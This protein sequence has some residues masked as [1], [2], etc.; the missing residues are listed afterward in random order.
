VVR[1]VDP[2]NE[3]EAFLAFRKRFIDEGIASEAYSDI[4]GVYNTLEAAAPEE[5]KEKA[6]SYATG[7]LDHIKGLY[8]SMDS[9]FN[10]PRGKKREG[11]RKAAGGGTITLDLKGTPCP[12]NYVKAKL[13]L[14]TLEAGATVEIYLDEGEPI[15]NVP[16]SLKNDGHII[17][18]IEKTGDF[19]TLVVVKSGNK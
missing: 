3:K 6:L 13:F 19:Y 17:S 14:E 10:F 16:D 11:D 18:S 15:N 4:E 1:G 2:G 12:L 5:E 8:S 7:F 9:G